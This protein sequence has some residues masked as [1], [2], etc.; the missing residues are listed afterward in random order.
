MGDSSVTY[1][2]M[3]TLDTPVAT[4]NIILESGSATAFENDQASEVPGNFMMEIQLT[5][6]KPRQLVNR[7]I[8]RMNLEMKNI[9]GQ[10]DYIR[11][12]DFTLVRTESAY[13]I[14]EVV[15]A[16]VK[17]YI[18]VPAQQLKCGDY[19]EYFVKEAD[20]HTPRVAAML[21]A[22]PKNDNA[23]RG[24]NA[25]EI[26][27]GIVEI[28]LSEDARRG[29]VFYSGEILHGLG[30]GNVYVEVGYELN[31]DDGTETGGTKS[32]IYGNPDIFSG[33]Q[34]STVKAETAVRVLNDKGSFVVG[35]RLWDSVDYLMISY[36]WVAIRFPSGEEVAAEIDTQG[37]SI[38]PEQPTVRMLTKESHYFGVRF[39][40][41]EPCSV[42]Y[43]L[44]DEGSGD[45]TADGVYTAPAKPGV[46]EIRIYCTDLP[47]VCTYAYAVVD[48]K[49]LDETDQKMQN[50]GLDQG[51]SNPVSKMVKI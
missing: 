12:A 39:D 1:F 16:T 34:K 32:T 2:W 15:E 19:L 11:L 44:T 8:G 28:P 51:G 48:K 46:Y 27:T 17:Q 18:S 30:R 7:E 21:D 37:M 20:I 38:A 50:M 24:K 9:G 25:P 43:E 41:L 36:R 22:A 10:G 14:E 3:E 35:A 6:L 5:S 4:T 29:D 13:I 33:A 42:T 45:I 31:S 49:G 47:K 26:A 40:G 23:G